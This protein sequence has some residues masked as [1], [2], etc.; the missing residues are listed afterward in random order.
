MSG[1]PSSP[2]DSP[3]TPETDA[4]QQR[5]ARR[6]AAA[7]VDRYSPLQPDVWQ[8]LQERQRALMRLLRQLGWASLADKQVLEVGCGAGGNLLELL[9]LAPM[10]SANSPTCGH[11]KL[12][13]ARTAGL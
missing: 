9:R 13:Q 10:A 1:Q 2:P 7:G 3:P 4:V 6:A 5:Y 11:P 12:G 8:T